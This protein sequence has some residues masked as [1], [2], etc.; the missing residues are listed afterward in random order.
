VIDCLR[1]AKRFPAV[2]GGSDAQ[3]RWEHLPE[4]IQN[5]D[6]VAAEKALFLR[7]IE[8]VRPKFDPQS[9]Q[10]FWEMVVEGKS[11]AEVSEKLGMRPG[12]V[13]VAKCRVLQKLRQQLGDVD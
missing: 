5:E 13:R 2:L 8:S 6:E 9:W 7:A 3:W 4:D 1:R 11:A 12:T 10:A